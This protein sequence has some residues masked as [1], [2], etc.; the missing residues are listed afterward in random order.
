MSRLD[1]IRSRLDEFYAADAETAGAIVSNAER[2]LNAH[3]PDDL[4]LLLAIAEA[5]DELRLYQPGRA[6]DA[7]ARTRLF[8]A[9]AALGADA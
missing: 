1:D 3:A 4:R 7:A 6:G 5:A 9:L 2:A 8:D